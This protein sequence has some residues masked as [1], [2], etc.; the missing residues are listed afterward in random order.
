[1]STALGAATG[2]LWGPLRCADISR[3][4]RF[5][6]KRNQT[7]PRPSCFCA[8]VQRTTAG[9][10]LGAWRRLLVVHHSLCSSARVAAPAFCQVRVRSTTTQVPTQPRGGATH[11]MA[12]AGT[13]LQQAE[14]VQWRARS[15][16]YVSHPSQQ[17]GV[18][19]II[20]TVM[21]RSWMASC[22]LYEWAQQAGSQTMARRGRSALG[23]A[24]ACR[25]LSAAR[26]CAG[27]IRSCMLCTRAPVLQP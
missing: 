26:R 18:I 14:G 11:G 12:G 23:A 7:S 25:P 1:M 27:I 6:T 24:A 16:A 17:P 13:I 22:A 3:S 10:S 8:C 15:V 5:R 19:E 2:L 4:C 9:S 21:L 20:C